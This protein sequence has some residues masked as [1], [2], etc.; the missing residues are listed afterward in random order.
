MKGFL[1]VDR[2]NDIKFIDVD[3]EFAHHINDQAK[4]CGLYGV[5][6]QWLLTGFSF[7]YKTKK[8][9][10][11]FNRGFNSG[12]PQSGGLTAGLDN[13]HIME[14]EKNNEDILPDKLIFF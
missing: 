5:S 7:W 11:G 6:C 1:V 8:K 10:T 14:W 4:Q 3:K 9:Q 12:H 2:L 13:D